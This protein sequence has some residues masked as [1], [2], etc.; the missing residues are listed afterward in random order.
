MPPR[1]TSCSHRLANEEMV[2]YKSHTVLLNSIVFH[3][4]LGYGN[5]GG[6]G[7]PWFLRTSE[8]K[9]TSGLP[10]IPHHSFLCMQHGGLNG[11][12]LLR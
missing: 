11:E 7:F 12:K 10:Q 9:N 2:C 3:D 5:E 6:S 8:K 1:K 4:G